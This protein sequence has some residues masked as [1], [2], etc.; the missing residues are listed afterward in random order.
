[1]SDDDLRKKIKPF[2]VKKENQDE[3][4]VDE[5]LRRVHY[6]HG[7]TQHYAHK[8]SNACLSEHEAIYIYI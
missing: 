3:A 2:L 5:F 8:C 7:N 4:V 6:R 1:M